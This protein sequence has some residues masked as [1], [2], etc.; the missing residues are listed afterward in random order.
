M[1]LTLQNHGDHLFIRSVSE[2]GI[3]VVDDFY[4]T[5]I[6]LSAREIVPDWPVKSIDDFEQKHLERVLDL[7]PE[8]V[9]IG[10]GNKQAFLPPE[11][12]MFFYQRNIGIEVMS[13][14]AACRTFNVL[15]SESRNVA[16]ALIPV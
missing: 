7:N 13:T 9:L 14:Q 11:L 4:K 8:I 6:I 10:T 15:V 3:Q 12:M 2:A 16:A 1:D 5:S